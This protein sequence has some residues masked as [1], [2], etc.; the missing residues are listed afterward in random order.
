M[1][2]GKAN[3]RCVALNFL[4][5]LLQDVRAGGLMDRF[6]EQDL[7]DDDVLVISAELRKIERRLRHELLDAEEAAEMEAEAQSTW[8]IR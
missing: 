4:V 7:E 3:A 2:I 5:D 6:P 1:V 8:R